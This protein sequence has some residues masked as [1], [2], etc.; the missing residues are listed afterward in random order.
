MLEVSVSPTTYAADPRSGLGR[1]D[2]EA[3]R[4]SAPRLLGPLAPPP[5]PALPCS[6]ERLGNRVAALEEIEID[7]VPARRP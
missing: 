1:L 7:P 5:L 6:A 2:R 3:A 4:R